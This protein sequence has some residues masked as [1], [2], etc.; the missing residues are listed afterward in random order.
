MSENNMNDNMPKDFDGNPIYPSWLTQ[1][2]NLQELTSKILSDVV[3]G[4]DLFATDF[5]Q[6]RRMDMCQVCEFYDKSKHRCTKCG[7]YMKYKV[8][9]KSSECPIDKW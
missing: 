5:E 7:C 8:T 1:A 4:D 6:Q 3:D 9:F 2:Q